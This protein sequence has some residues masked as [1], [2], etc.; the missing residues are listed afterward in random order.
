MDRLSRSAGKRRFFNI[1]IWVP[2]RRLGPEPPSR[3]GLA[4]C[5]GEPSD[6]AATGEGEKRR[7]DYT[8]ESVN[9]SHMAPNRYIIS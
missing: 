9:L 6:E 1:R 7:Q 4:V 2:T 8:G 5:V 3:A